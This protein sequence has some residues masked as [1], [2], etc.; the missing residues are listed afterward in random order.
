MTNPRWTHRPAA[1]STVFRA[2]MRAPTSTLWLGA[3]SFEDRC[4]ESLRMLAEERL[5]LGT[6]MLLDYPTI[7]RPVTEDQERRSKNRRVFHRLAFDICPVPIEERR[8]DPYS[9][10]GFQDLLR[11]PKSA[12]TVFDITCMTKIHTLALAATLSQAP[13]DREWA[14]AYSIPEN[15]GDLAGTNKTLGWRD[16]LIA[17]LAE[18]AVL[19]NETHSRGIIITGH[20]ADRL[21]VALGELDPSGGLIIVAD[22]PQRPDLRILSQRRNQ[23]IIR[24]LTSARR[25]AWQQV[26]VPL[27]ATAA[28]KEFLA[29]EIELAA[30][31]QAPILLFP[32]GPKPL[33]FLAAFELA[34]HYPSSSWFV[35]PVPVA[36]DVDYSEG[37]SKTIWLVSDGG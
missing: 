25:N 28:L 16:I 5:A 24:Q 8:V 19:F 1:A 37:V 3:L 21:I 34:S 11:E 13:A 32:F 35:Y 30:Q 18:T 15:Y 33:V 6:A 23:K 31:H 17:P 14:I 27:A 12:F 22:S 36:Y 10:Q 9:F 29:R 20:E 26:V 2:W 7:V 4:T